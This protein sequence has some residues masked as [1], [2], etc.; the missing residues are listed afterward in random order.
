MRTEQ[1]IRDK[2]DELQN[3]KSDLPRMNRSSL[4]NELF[5]KYNS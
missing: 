3:K 4:E 2:I 5:D 1:E